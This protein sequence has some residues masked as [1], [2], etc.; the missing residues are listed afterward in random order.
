MIVFMD[1]GFKNSRS[2][3]TDCLSDWLNVQKKLNTWMDHEKKKYSH[4]E[5]P[6]PPKNKW[7]Q[8][9]SRQRSGRYGCMDALLGR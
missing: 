1:S 8:L 5:P 7:N 9:S 3:T 6:L 2:S 4:S